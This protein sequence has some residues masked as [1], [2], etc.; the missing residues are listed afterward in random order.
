[1]VVYRLRCCLFFFFVIVG[2]G[3]VDVVIYVEVGM[4]EVGGCRFY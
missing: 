2:M 3:V 1:M 4:V